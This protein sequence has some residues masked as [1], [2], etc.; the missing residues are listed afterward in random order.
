VLGY[1]SF[2]TA[3]LVKKTRQRRTHQPI[4]IPVGV[5]T[6]KTL[7]CGEQDFRYFRFQAHVRR[8]LCRGHGQLWID[9]AFKLVAIHSV[10]R[11]PGFRHHKAINPGGRQNTRRIASNSWSHMR[12]MLLQGFLAW[13]SDR[14][15]PFQ[16]SMPFCQAANGTRAKNHRLSFLK[17]FYA[18][19][20]WKSPKDRW[21]TAFLFHR[22][23]CYQEGL[24][25]EVSQDPP[26]A[27]TF[28][29]QT[30]HRQ[31]GNRGS[32][33]YCLVPNGTVHEKANLLP[34]SLRADY[35]AKVGRLHSLLWP[36]PQLSAYWP[37][38]L[39]A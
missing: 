22:A 36:T 28:E 34:C 15:C 30:G 4:L 7:H 17:R 32:S 23:T 29:K 1:C 14:T 11:H 13:W 38:V 6:N 39:G 12:L 27:K 37:S 19:F 31:V 25:L 9:A 24:C 10:F 5:C 26:R 2:V 16:V 3:I 20:L 35:E 33:R 18:D 8:L 21:K